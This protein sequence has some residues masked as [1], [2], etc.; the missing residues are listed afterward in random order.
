MQDEMVLPVK[1]EEDEG[2]KYDV[3]ALRKLIAAALPKQNAQLKQ[4]SNAGT[5]YYF[6]MS[7]RRARHDWSFYSRIANYTIRVVG[8]L[9]FLSQFASFTGMAAAVFLGQIY[10]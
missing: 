5:L 7:I 1:R 8:I 6:R 3:V 10:P 4:L 9:V 2:E